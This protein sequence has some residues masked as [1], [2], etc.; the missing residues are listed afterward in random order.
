[1]TTIRKQ[2]TFRLLCEKASGFRI[3]HILAICVFLSLSK[4]HS[5]LHHSIH[6]N[7]QFVFETCTK[8]RWISFSCPFEYI[9]HV[10]P[11]FRCC[12]FSLLGK[13]KEQREKIVACLCFSW[14]KSHFYSLAD[15]C[16]RIY[17]QCK[18]YYLCENK[19]HS[20]WQPNFHSEYRGSRNCSV[21]RC[22]KKQRKM[23]N[24]MRAFSFILFALFYYPDSGLT[25]R[26]TPDVG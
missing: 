23:W 7:P 18:D 22:R 12:F 25:T 16:G 2:R 5:T 24:R 17:G 13:N 8:I 19:S 20:F 4:P 3:L 11:I 1:M 15:L 26:F 21:S 10:H 6:T 9:S 14:L